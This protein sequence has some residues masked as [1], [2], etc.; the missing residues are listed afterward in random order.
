MNVRSDTVV[1]GFRRSRG[2]SSD[3]TYFF[4]AKFSRPFDAWTIDVD[5]KL[6]AAETRKGRGVRVQARFDFNDP[7]QPVL[8]KIG[9]SAVSVEGARKNLVAEIPAWD[10][11]ATV[12][13]AAKDW[14]E[15]LGPIEVQTSDPATRETFYSN[16]YHSCIAPTLFNDA[17]GTY[18][19]PD[20]K[21]H[22]PE[23]FQYY[24]T[25]SLWDTFRAEHPLLTI[26]Q[27][28]RVDDFV[29]TML[30]HYRQFNEHKLPIWTLA[31][32]ETWCMIG[33]H[34]SR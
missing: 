25:F 31:G 20:H 23:G 16:L 28:Q 5:G 4:Y 22:K 7:A 11:D 13:A 34:P 2:W 24:S 26:I 18:V 9:L 6:L 3:H 19:G 8:V 17:D 1:S 33:N 15:V 14:S 10:F 12:T 30:A 29:G 27:P 21:A 32:N